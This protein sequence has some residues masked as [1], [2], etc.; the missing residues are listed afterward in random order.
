MTTNN[1]PDLP[2]QHIN[3]PDSFRS[4]YSPPRSYLSYCQICRYQGHAAKTC[5]Y[6][7][8][9][10]VQP[11]NT[12]NATVPTSKSP[13]QPQAYSAATASNNPILL[14][15]S[16]ASHHVTS[17]LSNLPLHEPYTGSDNIM[18]GDGTGLSIT[19][20]GSTSLKT[21]HTTF[22]LSN[23]LCVPSMKKKLDIYFSILHLK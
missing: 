4:V 5:P 19:H 23:V 9:V 16:G 1:S 8:L 22:T 12:S 20:T 13:R 15:D 10:P 17:K 3:F 2:N 18:I 6:F 7:R 14:L 11:F 21:P